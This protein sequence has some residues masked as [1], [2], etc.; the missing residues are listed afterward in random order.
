[1]KV[2]VA[3]GAAALAGFAATF[4]FF[5]LF[6]SDVGVGPTATRPTGVAADIKKD[7][8]TAEMAAFAK[9]GSGRKVDFE[10]FYARYSRTAA[11]I[12]ISDLDATRHEYVS[13][14]PGR[15]DLGS[16][17]TVQLEVEKTAPS[18]PA[19]MFSTRFLTPSKSF[20]HEFL[21]HPGTGAKLVR[22]LA[23]DEAISVSDGGGTW[24]IKYVAQSPA[25][26]TD[27][28]VNIAPAVGRSIGSLDPISQGSVVVRS[29]LI[30]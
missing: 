2:L 5:G 27:I 16:R 1:M 24:V 22:G 12:E 11:G 26:P 10:N 29:L 6:G 30:N 17:V 23:T 14:K 19:M 15:A 8:S 4:Y 25:E 18:G 28:R 13:W 7:V 20:D 3:I 9:S 21:F